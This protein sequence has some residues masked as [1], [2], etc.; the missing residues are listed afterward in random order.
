MA[1][2]AVKSFAADAAS[3]QV[4]VA[5]GAISQVSV[6]GGDVALVIDQYIGENMQSMPNTDAGLVWE[7]NAEDRKITASKNLE[8][9]AYELTVEA[10]SIS[11]T[12]DAS[13]AGQVAVDAQAQDLVDNIDK[14]EGASTLVYR[15]SADSAAG[16][17]SE[18]QILT[19]TITGN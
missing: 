3:H 5:V 19:Y 18:T 16:S 17:Q 10:A 9:P 7:T 14:G 8:D 11:G 13:P 6:T 2:M 4:T 12:S 1:L 15:A